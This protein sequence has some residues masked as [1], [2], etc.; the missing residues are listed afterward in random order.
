MWQ[1]IGRNEFNEYNNQN[2][3]IDS[4]PLVQV[5][6]VDGSEREHLGELDL[7]QLDSFR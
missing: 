7:H 5:T 4:H 1:D 2:N 3:A 6:F